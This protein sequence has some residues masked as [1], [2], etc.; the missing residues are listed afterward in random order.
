MEGQL[1]FNKRAY[2]FDLTQPLSIGMPLRSG[3]TNPSCF[4]APPP[5][6]IP[7]ES[8]DFIGSIKSGS[9]V[10]FYNVFLNPHGNGTH[11]ECSGHVFENG[12]VMAGLLEKRFFLCYL[13]SVDIAG[14]GSIGEEIFHLVPRGIEA[15]IVRTIPN[16][17]EK[18]TLDYSGKDPV[19][20]EPELMKAICD[21]GIQHFLIDLPSIDPESDG[22]QLLAHKAFWKNNHPDRT[23]CTI[24]ELIYVPQEI[25]DGLYALELQH[26]NI[27]LDAAPSEPLLYRLEEIKN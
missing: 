5:E 22:G 17:D 27:E 10:N 20:C 3:K 9:P 8:G 21:C 23:R 4:H 14:L 11:T 26:M 15:L 2:Y 7:Y 13:I 25:E 24:T 12:L 19:Y 16:G 18:L 1:L 6:F